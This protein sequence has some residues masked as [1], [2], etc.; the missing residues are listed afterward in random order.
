LRELAAADAVDRLSRD[1][2]GQLLTAGQQVVFELQG[3]NLRLIV[4]S[5]TTTTTDEDGGAGAG[6]SAAGGKQSQPHHREV[7]RAAIA[8]SGATTFVFTNSNAHAIRIT[9]QK[10]IATTAL[11]KQRQLNFE[12][13]GIGGL[14]RQFEAIFRRAFASR[15]FPPSVLERLGI[16]H[17]KGMLLYGPPGTGKTLIARQIGKML[18]GREP[19][20]VNGPEVLSKYVGQAEE[21]VRALFAEAEAE[22]KEKGDSS[23]L[24]IIIFDEIDAICKQRGTVRDGTATHDTIVNQL[25]TKID[26]VDA[27]NNI[28]LIGERGAGRPT[29]CACASG[30]KKKPSNARSPSH[31]PPTPL[32]PPPTPPHPTK[33]A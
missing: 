10:G 19:K 5:I 32:P 31:P 15:V 30:R 12:S 20:V 2:Q 4:G 29:N 9:G 33:Q 26:G 21:N 25:L 7:A 17:V 18:N 27:L 13:L 28:L 24:H 22:Y 1:L 11:F 3:A 14:D 8:G 16:H 6:G 23:E